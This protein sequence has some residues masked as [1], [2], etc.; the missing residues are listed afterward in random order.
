MTSFT[1]QLAATRANLER[2]EK[3][4]LRH[5]ELFEHA[6]LIEATPDH[7][8]VYIHASKDRNRDW[9]AWAQ[10]YPAGW[11]LEPSPSAWATHCD[12]TGTL[13]GVEISILQAE[14]REQSKALFAEQKTVA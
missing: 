7:N 4:F 12:F 6:S 13:D 11:M 14:A 1:D 8:R 10:N 9:R 3:L 2:L 5:P